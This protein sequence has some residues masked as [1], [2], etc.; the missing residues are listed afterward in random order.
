VIAV[1]VDPKLTPP[2]QAGCAS[3][4]AVIQHPARGM[5]NTAEAF[6]LTV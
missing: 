4:K 6:A 3:P 1:A 5:K 2:E